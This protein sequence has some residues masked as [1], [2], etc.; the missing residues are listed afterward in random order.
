MRC[1]VYCKHST[2][3]LISCIEIGSLMARQTADAM[4]IRFVCQPNAHFYRIVYNATVINGAILQ[5]QRWTDLW[6]AC[7]YAYLSCSMESK[8]ARNQQS[9]SLVSLDMEIFN[10]GQRL[11]MS[12]FRVQFEC[13]GI[14]RQFNQIHLNL[15]IQIC[16]VFAVTAIW[17]KLHL[18]V[19]FSS[20]LN[21]SNAIKRI[22]YSK[23]RRFKFQ[24]D[25]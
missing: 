25:K 24:I 3:I 8:T 13:T 22:W 14:S 2:Y 6:F 19:D 4:Q 12:F 16:V 7:F 1:T 21:C 5:K 9:L 11:W 20:R 10:Y 18:V 15:I 23:A 17:S